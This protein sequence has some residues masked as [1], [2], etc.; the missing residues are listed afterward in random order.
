MSQLSEPIPSDWNN[1][2][3]FT[4]TDSEKIQEYK[5]KKLFRTAEIFCLEIVC[6]HTYL[7]MHVHNGTYTQTYTKTYTCVH[8]FVCV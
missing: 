1:C 4:R 8:M 5:T 3:L 7:N 6:T 2:S